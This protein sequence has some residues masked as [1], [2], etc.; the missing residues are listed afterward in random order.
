M[1]VYAGSY[2][3]HQCPLNTNIP[4]YLIVFGC[5]SI[6]QAFTTNLQSCLD[7]IFGF[8]NDESRGQG[9]GI[10]FG[11][12]NCLITV[13]SLVWFI[14]GSYWIFSAW[15]VWT[16]VANRCHYTSNG[17]PHC[18]NPVLMYFAFVF[19]LLMYGLILLFCCSTCMIF[20]IGSIVVYLL[21]PK[22]KTS[23]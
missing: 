22:V 1:S 20:G 18:C 14:I 23:W 3:V 19:Q 9:F 5:V 6:V 10:C 21:L 7:A 8:S 15:I 16:E 11:C 13:F 12:F 17:P 4:I 2:Y